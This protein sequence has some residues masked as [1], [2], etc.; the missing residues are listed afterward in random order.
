MRVSEWLSV[1]RWKRAVT[2]VLTHPNTVTHLP[3]LGNEL[4]GQ[5]PA[6][7]DEGTVRDSARE[8]PQLRTGVWLRSASSPTV[9]KIRGRAFCVLCPSRGA[10]SSGEQV[11]WMYSSV[12][13]APS[14]LSGAHSAHSGFM[15]KPGMRRDF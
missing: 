5:V 2:A 10:S 1:V 7:N 14:L 12:M 13:L 6:E 3:E 8:W 11:V 15:G 4:R 9:F